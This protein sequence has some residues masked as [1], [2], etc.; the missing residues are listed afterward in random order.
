MAAEEVVEAERQMGKT[1]Q[2][3]HDT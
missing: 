3:A 2:A 1:A